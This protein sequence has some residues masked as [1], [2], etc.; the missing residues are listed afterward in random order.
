MAVLVRNQALNFSHDP[1]GS[2]SQNNMAKAAR[3][4]VLDRS[5]RRKLARPGAQI[6][7][8]MIPDRLMEFYRNELKQAERYCADHRESLYRRP[9]FFHLFDVVLRRSS[10]LCVFFRLAGMERQALGPEPIPERPDQVLEHVEGYFDSRSRA[11]QPKRRLRR[12]LQVAAH[13]HYGTAA[14]TGQD[15]ADQVA[16]GSPQKVDRQRRDLLGF[17]RRR[18]IRTFRTP[19]YDRKAPSGLSYRHISWGGPSRRV[20]LPLRNRRRS[21]FF[22]PYNQR[23]HGLSELDRPAG[24]SQFEQNFA[25]KKKASRTR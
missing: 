13:Q 19:P 24:I 22:R 16:G 6:R 17:C 10:K 11:I 23:H 14:G 20:L 5:F 4:H 18:N 25:W 9:A 2:D 15:E 1:A 3:E 12:Y 21:F 8:E 7:F